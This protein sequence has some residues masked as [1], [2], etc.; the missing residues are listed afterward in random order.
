MDT[1]PQHPQKRTFTPEQRRVLGRLYGF[2]ISVGE[3]R[4]RRLAL[5]KEQAE[6]A[7]QSG[8]KRRNWNSASSRGAKLTGQFSQFGKSVPG[9]YLRDAFSYVPGAIEIVT[10]IGLFFHPRYNLFHAECKGEKYDKSQL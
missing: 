6:K 2:L 4:L 1:T 3:K 10:Q 7:G 9:Y 5:E 8:G